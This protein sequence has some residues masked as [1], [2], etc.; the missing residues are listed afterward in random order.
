MQ[1][2]FKKQKL[3]M[4]FTVEQ[5]IQVSAKQALNEVPGAVTDKNKFILPTVASIV[6]CRYSNK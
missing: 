1:K 2:W 5:Y 4:C 6:H 3:G